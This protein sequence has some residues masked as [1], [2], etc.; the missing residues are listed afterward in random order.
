M[1]KNGIHNVNFIRFTV[2]F[3]FSLNKV[4]QQRGTKRKQHFLFNAYSGIVNS[5]GF[6]GSKQIGVVQ[7]KW[8]STNT[9]NLI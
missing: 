1:I 2:G 4:Y 3:D 6:S 7:Y 9:K 8:E 5:C